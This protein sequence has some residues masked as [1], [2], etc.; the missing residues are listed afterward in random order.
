MTMAPNQADDTPPIDP[1]VLINY[2]GR[3][4]AFILWF[5]AIAM[6]LIGKDVGPLT[7]GLLVLQFFLYPHLLYWRARQAANPLEAEMLN[8]LIDAGL[9]GLWC[10][11]LGFPVLITFA[12]N[13]YVVINVAFYRGAMGAARA[14]LCFL[15]GLLL[16]AA[17]PGLALDL[18]TDWQTTALLATA[19][20]IYIVTVTNVSYKRY[21][22]L[23][24]ALEKQRQSEQALNSANQALQTQLAD[25][26]ELQA[27]LKEQANRDPL[28]SLY[29]RR[30][31]D[32]TIERELARSKRQ[33]NPLWLML[34]D[35][36]HFK[37]VNDTYGHL[38]GDEVIKKLALLLGQRARA[39]DVVCRFGGEEFLLLL[40]NM[41]E[42]VARARA[43]QWRQAFADIVIEFETSRIQN[44]LS[45][46]MAA[47][48][49]HGASAEALIGNADRALYKAKS[50]GRNRVVVFDEALFPA[51]P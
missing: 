19:M 12:L 2:R 51:T 8:Q 10:A 24:D 26:H 34:I 25:I 27:Q 23:N 5:M 42:K 39:E 43:E 38:A 41:T 28:T 11:A 35:I 47:Y 31:L 15:L 3:V 40:P 7:W 14:F 13:M 32:S 33:V 45:I 4:G 1:C 22:L 6:H 44:T 17:L 16:G 18:S 50:D 49:A 20:T 9:L 36:D 21:L 48:S 29:N 37:K 30:Y 46:G